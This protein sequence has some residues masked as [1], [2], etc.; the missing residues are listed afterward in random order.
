MPPQ[1]T[2]MP[3]SF[4]GDWTEFVDTPLTGKE[5]GQVKRKIERQRKVRG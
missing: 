4:H 2:P 3:V 5:L 1:I